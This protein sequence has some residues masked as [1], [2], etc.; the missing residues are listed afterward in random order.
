VVLAIPI[1]ALSTQAATGWMR[2]LIPDELADHI[3]T[4]KN[5]TREILDWAELRPA[6]AQAGLLDRERLFV[7]TPQWHQ[8][9]KVDVQLGDRLPVVCLCTDPRNIAFGHDPGDFAGWDA[10]IVG[11]D[12]YLPDAV[13]MYGAY[14]RSIEPLPPV[15]VSL[16]GVP[17]LTLRL[18]LAHDYYRPYPMRLPPP[19]PAG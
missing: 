9:G 7:V 14:F 12:H 15:T 10:L 13:A 3:D 17:D 11:S 1:L 4:G 19:R 2:Y 6:V 16:G 18:Y 8:A 5:P